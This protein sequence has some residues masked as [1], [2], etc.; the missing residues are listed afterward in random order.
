MIWASRAL[1]RSLIRSFARRIGQL[2]GLLLPFIMPMGAPSAVAA[3][4]PATT[5]DKAKPRFSVGT[6]L[7]AASV[8]VRANTD[9]PRPARTELPWRGEAWGQRCAK[10]RHHEYGQARE[11]SKNLGLDRNSSAKGASRPPR[12]PPPIGGVAVRDKTSYGI[13]HGRSAANLDTNK[14]TRSVIE[15]IAQ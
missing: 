13:A 15:S 5:T 6:K 9:A 8:A 4:R 1:R 7:A 10:V 12:V 11:Q 3:L 14:L 2:D